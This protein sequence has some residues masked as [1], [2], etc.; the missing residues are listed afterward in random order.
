L[1][2]AVGE[3]LGVHTVVTAISFDQRLGDQIRHGPD[4][5][6]QRGAVTHERRRDRRDRTV[7]V[8][9]LVAR[10][11]GGTLVAVDNHVDVVERKVM[12][13]AGERSCLWEVR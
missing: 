1:K 8:G 5:C 7:L 4:T 13:E 3:H 12:I 9:H 10:E 11:D 2:E 6:L